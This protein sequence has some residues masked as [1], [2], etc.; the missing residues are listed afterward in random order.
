MPCVGYGPG[1]LRL[2]YGGGYY[3]RLLGAMAPEARPATLGIAFAGSE[4]PGL[5][6]APHD[7]ALDGILTED[8]PAG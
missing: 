7:I 4:L 3:D 1:G 2:G 6:A 5:R 8:G